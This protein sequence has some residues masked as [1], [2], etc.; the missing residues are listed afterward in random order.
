MRIVVLD[1]EG[2]RG[3]AAA[4]HLCRALGKPPEELHVAVYD[5]PEQ[6]M[7]AVAEGHASYLVAPN[8]HGRINELYMDARLR[9]ER[10][11]VF[12]P[13]V[14]TTEAPRPSRPPRLLWSAFLRHAL[15][16]LAGS[17]EGATA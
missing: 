9:L 15:P 10:A 16:R 12:E 3:A 4:W 17:S 2:G 1:D 13:H 14:A 6:A 5:S 8:G 11:F 7:D